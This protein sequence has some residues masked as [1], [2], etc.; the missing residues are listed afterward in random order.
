[1]AKHL[2]VAH[3]A[4][5]ADPMNNA[6]PEG[7][8]CQALIFAKDKF[9][10]K[11]DAINWAKQNNYRY[12]ALTEEAESYRLTQKDPKDFD[13]NLRT[14]DI[15]TGVKAVS[16][17]IKTTTDAAPPPAAPAAG[18]GDIAEAITLLKA[19]DAKLDKL[20]AAEAAEDGGS[21]P[22]PPADPA[23]AAA[24]AT[25][26]I[27]ADAIKS[28]LAPITAKLEKSDANMGTLAKAVEA[29]A[30]KVL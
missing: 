1:M 11:E 19:L 24:E 8:V 22:P 12:D 6:I 25:A 17:K 20:I 26:R 16:G 9:T 2:T 23:K 3:P 4:Y 27:V 7:E 29:M 13:G 21:T 18:T 28:A 30:T 5:K 10:T 14:I 15:T